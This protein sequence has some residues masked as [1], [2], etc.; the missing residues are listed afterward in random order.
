MAAGRIH[1]GIG[2]WAYAP[3]R[4]T[5]YPE[6]LRQA[7]ELAYVAARLTATE[8]NATFYGRQKPETF[9]KWAKAVPDGFRFA[10]KASRYCTNRRVLAEA[11]ESIGRFLDQGLVRLEDRLGPILWQLADSKAFD[12]EDIARFLGLLPPSHDGVPLAHA[13]EPRHQSFSDP[14]FI[15]LARDHGVAIVVADHASRP[16]IADVTAGFVY[17]RLQA[18]SEDEPDGYA[19]RALDRWARIAREW[20]E[21]GQPDGLAV[22]A[23]AAPAPR[24]SRDVFVFMI[25]GAKVRAPAAAQ[26]LIGRLG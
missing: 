6:G 15:D 1:V 7:D 5:F 17:A 24:G 11:G 9:E 20:S 23:P 16:Q 3:W 10:L 18:A 22:A 2:G 4:G 8:V 13:I 12:A 21:G 19:P 26:A 25:N 14:H